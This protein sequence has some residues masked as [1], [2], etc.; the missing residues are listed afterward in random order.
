M[1]L[2]VGSHTSMVYLPRV[3]SAVNAFLKENTK[4]VLVII[5][6]TLNDVEMSE[7]KPRIATSMNSVEAEAER[8][9]EHV[10]G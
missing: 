8:L 3:Y 9:S 6:L 10:A 5:K 4:Q 7:Y 2:G 1:H